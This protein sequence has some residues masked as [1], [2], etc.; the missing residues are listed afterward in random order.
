M[1]KPSYPAGSVSTATMRTEDL[2]PAFIAQLG[3]LAKST[4]CIVDTV[5]AAGHLVLIRD[6]ES[7]M[8]TDDYFESDDA[9]YDLNESLFDALN[10]Y[11]APNCYFGS[12]PGDGA[13]YGFWP[14]DDG[15][16]E[17]NA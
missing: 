3:Y 1:S 2:I 13:D 4:P 5:T 15:A 11:A 17:T 7:R 8:E 14:S 10:E 9:G 6:I 12:H 16:E